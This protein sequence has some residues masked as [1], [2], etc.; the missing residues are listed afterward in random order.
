MLDLKNAGLTELLNDFCTLTDMKLCIFDTDYQE[1]AST[2]IKL[3][4]FCARMRKI[5]EFDSRCRSCDEAHMQICRRS[6]KPLQYQCHAGLTEYLAPLYYEGVIVAFVCIGQATYGMDAEFDKIAQYAAQFG[7][8]KEE[9]HELY[10]MQIHYAP[11]TI[12]A[13]CRIL[14]ACI[15]HIYHQRMLEV[16]NLDTAQ[17][18][19]K[20]I[21]DNIAWDLSIEHLCAHFSVSRAELYQI[22][23][24]SFNSSVADYIRSKRI[25]MAEQMI[26]TTAL[27]I[28]EIASNV[29]FYD[30]N[31]F[32]KVFHRKFGCSPREYRKKLESGSEAADKK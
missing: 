24:M 7:I 1:C 11:R 22:F 17:Q 6:R 21:N 19:E 2:P 20:Y 14:D 3:Y 16:R 32:S 28:S 12:Q 29:G 30:Y 18:I 25:S 5:E 4:P 31:Y 8:C 27:Q 26:R 13:A 23:H 9:C 10:D 15:S